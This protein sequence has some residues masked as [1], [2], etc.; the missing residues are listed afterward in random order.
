MSDYDNFYSR[1][2]W[3]FGE[4]GSD[5]TI[6][7]NRHIGT[8]FPAAGGTSVP[9]L[10]AGTVVD[11]VKTSTMSWGVITSIGGGLYA[12]YWHLSATGLPF[13][14]QRLSRGD[15]VGRVARGPKG[16]AY[17]NPEF[18]GTAWYGPHCHVVVSTHIASAYGYID[19][20]RTLSAFRNPV[21]FIVRGGDSAGSEEEDD[22]FTEQDRARLNAVYAALFGPSAVGGKELSWKEV[23]GSVKTSK[24]GVLP[25]V[26]HNQT[27]AAQAVTNT[28]PPKK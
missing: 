15:R 27:L 17:S 25:V 22:M 2:S 3:S 1:V 28:N 18:P 21:D 11:I 9:A 14:G 6:V 7:K 8:D 24:Y 20:H 13:K 5:Y 10:R 26:L 23:D 4:Y 16:I 19:G 12:S